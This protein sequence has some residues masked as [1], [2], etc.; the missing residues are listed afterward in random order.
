MPNTTMT[1]NQATFELS[2]SDSEIAGV[3]HLTGVESFERD[4][5]TVYVTF[6]DGRCEEFRDALIHGGSVE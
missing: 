5:G 6:A 1:E 4:E 2:I 3:Q